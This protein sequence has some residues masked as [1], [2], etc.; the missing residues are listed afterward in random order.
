VAIIR[1]V[2]LEA[3]GERLLPDQQR[4]ELV[5]AEHLARY[6]FAIQ[7]ARGRRVLDAAS[8]EGYGTAML[9]ASGA[10]A[11]VGVELDLEAVSHAR[12]KYG[13]EFVQADVCDLPFDESSF[14]LVVSF[15]TIEHVKDP[16]R[17]VSEFRRVLSAGG[18]LVISTPN[19]QESLVENE[20]H[21]REFSP[22]EF[23]ALLGAHFGDVHIMLQQNWLLSAVLGEEQFRSEDPNRP[24]DLDLV[25]VEAQDPGKQ[26]YSIAICG[27]ASGPF[28]ETAVATGIFEAHR[29]A[30]GIIEAQNQLEAWIER[31]HEA[32]RLVSAWVERAHEAE[33]QLEDA[34]EKIE[35]I[36]ASASWRVTKPLRWGKARAT[37]QRR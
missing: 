24:L 6:R 1:A 17:A 34:R 19:S 35:S 9:A 22:E 27:G 12:E 18:V 30:Q 37:R 13:L 5:H 8:G 31:A 4:G 3:T 32:E 11:A 29:L 15:E 28:V 25:K 23:S 7:F 36:E 21:T 26:L 20:F 16:A 2:M 14:E 10:G 33:R